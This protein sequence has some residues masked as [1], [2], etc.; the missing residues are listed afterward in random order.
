[1]RSR[2]LIHGE[3]GGL[4]PGARRDAAN[5]EKGAAALTRHGSKARSRHLAPQPRPP[6]RLRLFRRCRSKDQTPYRRRYTPL[7]IGL[8]L[9]LMFHG[10]APHNLKTSFMLGSINCAVNRLVRMTPVAEVKSSAAKRV[11]IRAEPLERSCHALRRV[12]EN[13]RPLSLRYH[14]LLD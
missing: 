14:P 4:T 11:R 1:M 9:V 10:R 3:R 5:R 12:D 8:A 7:S 13:P 6:A 2:Q